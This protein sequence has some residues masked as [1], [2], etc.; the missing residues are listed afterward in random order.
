M[1]EVAEAAQGGRENQMEG[2]GNVYM[3]HARIYNQT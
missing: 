2:L 1:W 3:N